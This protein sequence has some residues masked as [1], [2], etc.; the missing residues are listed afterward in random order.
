MFDVD[1]MEGPVP[2]LFAANLEVAAKVLA[3]IP[4]MAFKDLQWVFSKFLI[5]ENTL[6][7]AA[8]PQIANPRAPEVAFPYRRT[9]YAFAKS[10]R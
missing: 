9:G 7:E 2:I 8:M 4:V 10:L 3:D 6:A 1:V 5:P